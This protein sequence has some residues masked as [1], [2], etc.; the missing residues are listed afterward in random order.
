MK[1]PETGEGKKV[2]T[3][4][5]SNT[6]GLLKTK[7]QVYILTK[8]GG[9]RQ[10]KDR[11]LEPNAHSSPKKSSFGKYQSPKT[12]NFLTIKSPKFL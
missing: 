1:E 11:R 9:E 8:Q 10:K 3:T 7:P 6:A 4:G 12:H 5:A 2:T